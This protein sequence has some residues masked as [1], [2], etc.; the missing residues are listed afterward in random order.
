M[1]LILVTIEYIWP[2]GNPLATLFRDIALG[3]FTYLFLYWLLDRQ[4]IQE[5]WKLANLPKI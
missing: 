4:K 3:S 1:L 5:I 2:L